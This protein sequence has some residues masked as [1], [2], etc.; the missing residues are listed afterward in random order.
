MAAGDR[1]KG[2]AAG[3]ASDPLPKQTWRV[4]GLA[5]VL[6]LT[7]TVGAIGLISAGFFDPKP[8]GELQREISL[9]TL[10]VP[11]RT[12]NIYWLEYDPHPES[13]SLRLSGR[14]QSGSPDS[15]Y[16]LVLGSEESVLLAAV[17][18]AG[19]TAVREIF[20]LLPQ[21]IEGEGVSDELDNSIANGPDGER[22]QADISWPLAG[23]AEADNV[24]FEWQ[25]WPH[26]NSGLETNEIWLDK[27]GA[28]FTIWLNREILWQGQA[29][30]SGS[31]I[32]L[33]AGSFTGETEELVTVD[34]DTLTVYSE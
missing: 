6:L 9:E 14:F 1:L 17:S 11:G 4:L 7:V 31:M 5:A 29:A 13:F 34:F 16:G 22:L 2:V 18:P 8:V 10:S 28:D 24:L 15:G 32:G 21:P 33:W 19:Y 30:L 3:S 25:T 23:S 20:P 26:I 12:Q 27:R